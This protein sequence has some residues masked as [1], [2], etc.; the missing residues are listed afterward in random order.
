MKLKILKRISFLVKMTTMRKLNNVV[1][2]IFGLSLVIL[3]APLFLLEKG[4]AN[5]SGIESPS[6][7]VDN[8]SK[9]KKGI[10]W[11][12][13]TQK[14]LQNSTEFQK[15]IKSNEIK[16]IDEIKSPK[17][18]TSVENKIFQIIIYDLAEN[19]SLFDAKLN[20]AT[21]SWEASVSNNGLQY[22]D[23]PP[24]ILSL[25]QSGIKKITFEK[26]VNSMH[27]K[28]RVNA[29]KG[30]KL[31]Q[32]KITYLKN[33]I[34]IKINSPIITTP[35]SLTASDYGINNQLLHHYNIH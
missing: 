29:F 24:K 21:N 13:S 23:I 16:I 18:S 4:S 1:R 2:I 10:R 5:E 32:P 3:A 14:E 31:S 30:M 9:D 19:T 11:S 20:F 12:A 6:E 35:S 17:I 28:L 34:Y 7:N 22:K 15:D 26:P 8:R 25:E 27:F 33:K